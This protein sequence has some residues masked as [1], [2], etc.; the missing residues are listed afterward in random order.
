MTGKDALYLDS[1]NNPI[2]PDSVI[3]GSLPNVLDGKEMYW[4][5]GKSPDGKS[6]EMVSCEF[7][8]IHDLTPEI[9]QSFELIGAVSQFK[10]LLQC[11]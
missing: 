10:D 8:Y 1:N 9:I 4:N 2:Q 5:F 6:Y 7:G 3:K 11:D